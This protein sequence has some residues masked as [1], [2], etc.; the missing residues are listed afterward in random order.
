MIAE[1][2]SAIILGRCGRYILRD[3]PRH[4]SVL[5]HADMAARIKRVGEL[6]HMSGD[7]AKKCIETNDKERTAYIRTFARQDWLDARLYDLCI[8]TSSVGLDTSVT[9]VLACI[10]A[11]IS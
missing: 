8:H 9:L 5:V 7:E 10:T 11:K 4:V 1:K 2:T 3:H 6:W